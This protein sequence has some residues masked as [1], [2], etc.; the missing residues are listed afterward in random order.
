MKFILE[1]LR[2]SY[3]SSSIGQSADFYWDE[4][5]DLIE[6]EP[7]DFSRPEWDESVEFMIMDASKRSFFVSWPIFKTE[8]EI[9]RIELPGFKPAIVEIMNQILSCEVHD[10]IARGQEDVEEHCNL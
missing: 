7:K 3:C 2:F 10:R 4:H 1:Y 6:E 8:H 5:N 9:W